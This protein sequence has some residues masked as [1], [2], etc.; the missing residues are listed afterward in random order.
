MP[1]TVILVKTE[2]TREP[3]PESRVVTFWLGLRDEMRTWSNRD[4]P[5]CRVIY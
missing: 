3:V 2:R 5:D 1:G 4:V